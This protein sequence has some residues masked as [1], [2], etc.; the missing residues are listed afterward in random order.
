MTHQSRSFAPVPYPSA[1]RTEPP[2]ALKTVKESSGNE[3]SAYATS[4]VPH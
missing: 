3:R 1:T 2:S 4:A